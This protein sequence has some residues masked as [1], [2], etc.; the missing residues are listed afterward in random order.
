MSAIEKAL[1]GFSISTTAT[2]LGESAERV[3]SMLRQGQL[4]LIE[5]SKG[6]RRV[7]RNAVLQLRHEKWMRV[8]A[9]VL[10]LVRAIENASLEQ[11]AGR[12]TED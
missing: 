6:R 10:E 11:I 3:E 2:L 5:L 4:P 12:D 7:E 1:S 9:A 8:E